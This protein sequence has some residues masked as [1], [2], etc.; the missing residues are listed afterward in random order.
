MKLFFKILLS[1][2]ALLTLSVFGVFLYLNNLDLDKH[3]PRISRLFFEQTGRELTI[4]GDAG[5]TLYPWL[6]LNLQD[7]AISDDPAFSD[8]NIFSASLIEFRA[9]LLPMLSGKYEIDSV[10]LHDALLNLEVNASGTGNWESLVP[11]ED[12]TETKSGSSPLPELI[13]GGID[14]QNLSVFYREADSVTALE[15]L[16]FTTDALVLGEPLELNLDGSFQLGQL[17][18]AGDFTLDGTLTY[19]LNGQAYSLTPLKLDAV[20]RGEN[21]PGG[22]APL[23]LTASVATDL[24]TMSVN[25]DNVTLNFLNTELKTSL[26]AEDLQDDAVVKARAEINGSDL[27]TLVAA[28]GQDSLASQI[29]TT[30]D[31]GINALVDFT[32]SGKNQ[33]LTLHS[34]DAAL[35]GAEINGQLTASLADGDLPVVNG[36]LNASGPD[37]PALM[38]LGG[39]I[40]G[41][42]SA[43]QMYGDALQSY[44]GS[45]QFSVS[46]R[47]D[48]DPDA[49]NFNIPEM[50]VTI[51]G[52]NL[53]G[54]LDATDM[55]SNRGQA[56]GEFALQGNNLKPLLRALEQ[57]QLAEVL[58][59]VQ[60]NLTLNGNRQALRLDP[61]VAELG[62]TGPDI[63]DGRST[64][65]FNASSLANLAD[66][67][68]Q[69]DA[70]TL[71]G[72]GLNVSG[73]L[74]GSQLRDNP[75]LN[76]SL[77]VA[78][79]NPRQLM[80][81]L[82][83]PAIE[84]QDTTVLANLS[85]QSDFSAT[86][87]LLELDNL[88]ISLDDSSLTGSL[89]LGV[90][91]IK[92][93]D[94]DISIDQINL[95]RY[96]SP[97][98]DAPQNASTA[99]S[100]LPVETLRTLSANGHLTVGEL[101]VSGMQL[102]D[103]DATLTAEA[104][105]IRLS[106]VTAA[107][108]DGGF[109]GDITLDVT[110]NT[111]MA[112]L[113]NTFKGINLAPLLQDF[114][115]TELISG[116]GDIQM[117]LSGSGDNPVAIRQS[118]SG[119]GNLSLVDGVLTG[120][121][122]ASVLRQ[123][124]TMIDTRQLGQVNRGEQTPFDS[125]SASLDVNQGVFTTNDMLLAS[126]GFQVRGNGTLANLQTEQVNFQ[127]VTSIDET[128]VTNETT[129]Y[130]LGGYELPIACTGSLYSPRCLP[131]FQQI[132]TA[133]L[134]QEVRSQL[135]GLLQ[136]ALG[137]A[138]EEENTETEEEEDPR[139]EVLNKVLEGFFN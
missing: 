14:I 61:L 69:V 16:S 94:F 100:A 65:Q 93:T 118:L 117:T 60:M 28:L 121:D 80:N 45:K 95:D 105:K 114:S 85:L 63:P 47:F 88:N 75:Q 130:N 138:E 20:V 122:V 129:E 33:E 72:L 106:P 31:Q 104:G 32:Y 103:I 57:T 22:S 39:R 131:D 66:E 25:A 110:G 86:D 78:S 124:E 74:N 46:A 101:T 81:S 53:Q 99:D 82:N 120:V 87:K 134:G 79:F 5:F 10:R 77:Q 90:G 83:L 125:F 70:F 127:L 48:V 4:N 133:A 107:L 135:G 102:S 23:S 44:P 54:Q 41:S 119:R 3:K 59:S 112:T 137:G 42:D 26:S 92:Q 96:Q 30:G 126:P 98:I 50:Q 128:T 108:Y 12:G 64:L 37:L 40:M 71:I 55:N 38:Q 97:A 35:L 43:L 2:F 8:G 109:S 49:G 15:G 18:I 116:I 34:L 51:P 6:S 36:N 89:V 58:D 76:G 9:K 13:I 68:M 24:D 84:T 123:V 19:D 73:N 52:I 111:P 113:S 1:L 115:G 56:Q 27:A 21:V 29:R 17:S 136:R 139:R 91:E 62:F 132:V 7:V 67:S 11:E